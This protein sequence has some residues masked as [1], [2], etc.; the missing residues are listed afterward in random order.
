MLKHKAALN[1]PPSAMRQDGN[2]VVICFTV[3]PGAKENAIIKEHDLS[4]RVDIH[5]VPQNGKANE[6]LLRYVASV[7][8]KPLSSVTLRQGHSSRKKLVAI[9]DLLLSEA[10]SILS[11]FLQENSKVV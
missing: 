9:H 5:A 2:T 1:R 3:R 4:I 6:S 10:Q 7:F 11:S 8:H